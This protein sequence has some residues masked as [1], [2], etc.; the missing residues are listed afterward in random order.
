MLTEIKEV[1]SKAKLCR[2][3]IIYREEV[4][5]TQVVEIFFI[6]LSE[7]TTKGAQELLH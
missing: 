3:D 7:A 5:C 4:K 1:D 2:F 6:G